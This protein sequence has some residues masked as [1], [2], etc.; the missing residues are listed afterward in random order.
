MIYFCIP[1][2]FGTLDEPHAEP[3][4]LLWYYIIIEVFKSPR[5]FPPLGAFLRVVA[6]S[7]NTFISSLHLAFAFS[8]NWIASSRVSLMVAL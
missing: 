5:K 3:I 2:S 7:N 6:A 4:E 8:D 1:I